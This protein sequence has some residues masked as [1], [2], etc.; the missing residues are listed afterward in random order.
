MERVENQG[1]PTLHQL[2]ASLPEEERVVLTLHIVKSLSTGE[3]AERL[4]VPERAV[5]AVL[6]SGRARL[7]TALNFPTPR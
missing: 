2:I 5:V 4:G 6:T 1:S 3:I 7:T